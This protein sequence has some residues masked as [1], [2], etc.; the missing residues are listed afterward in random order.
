[1]SFQD[2]LRSPHPFKGGSMSR[3][4]RMKRGYTVYLEE[5]NIKKLEK[6]AKKK[7]RSSSSIINEYIEKDCKEEHE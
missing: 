4:I 3:V 7:R 2:K 6:Y 1:M 5:E